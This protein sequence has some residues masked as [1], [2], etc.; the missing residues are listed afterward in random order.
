VSDPYSDPDFNPSVD[1]QT[2][3]RTTGILCMPILDRG[4]E[5]FAVAQLLNRKVG[6]FTQQD[7]AEFRAFAEPLAVILQSSR[8]IDRLQIKDHPDAA[9]SARRTAN[10]DADQL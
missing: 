6:A 7:E 8:I 3:Y 5:V 10:G 2:G 1:R 4:G 9:R